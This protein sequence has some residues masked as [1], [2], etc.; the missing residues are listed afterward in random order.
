MLTILPISLL[1]LRVAPG[2]V[3][4]VVRHGVP[5]LSLEGQSTAKSRALTALAPAALMVPLVAAAEEPSFVDTLLASDEARSLALF[6]GQT[7]I[8]WGV[9]GV[10]LV[11]VI[12]A[13]SGPPS[14][15]GGEA[16][17][18]LEASLAKALGMT[19]EP[20]EFLK[21]QRLNGKLQ[22]FNY[23]LTKA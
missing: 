3:H 17:S 23:S 5:V 1:A 11:A 13:A 9:P 7:I 2:P 19:N 6:L 12:I 16:V 15:E 22:S 10:V 8:S 4:S 20:K 21:V 18:P 14:V